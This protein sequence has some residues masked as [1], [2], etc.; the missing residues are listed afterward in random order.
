[1]YFNPHSRVGS[2]GILYI[3]LGEWVDFNPHSRVGSDSQSNPSL[4][5]QQI[6][7]HTPA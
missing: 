4:V 7:I 6:S 3:P 5:A 2:D 1:M